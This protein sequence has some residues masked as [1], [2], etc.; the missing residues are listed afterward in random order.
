MFY[1]EKS[2]VVT[3][4]TGKSYREL[5]QQNQVHP[6]LRAFTRPSRRVHSAI[7]AVY[8]PQSAF[9]RKLYQGLLR[10]VKTIERF[11]PIE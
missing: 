6:F 11:R 1:W 3:I 8:P 5:L 9:R 2:P 7:K 4:I 10:R